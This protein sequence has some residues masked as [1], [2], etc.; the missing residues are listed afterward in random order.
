M[1]I[2][3]RICV[4][5]VNNNI[6]NP[7]SACIT[8]FFYTIFSG[9]TCTNIAGAFR[10]TLANLQQLNPSLNCAA[11]TPGQRICVPRIIKK[12]SA[13]DIAVPAVFIPSPNGGCS[14]FFGITSGDTCDTIANILK[15]SVT[16]LLT[17]NP[18]LNCDKLVM[19]SAIC[20]PSLSQNNNNNNNIQPCLN[21]YQI[22]YGDI[23]FD[24]AIRA[25]ISLGDFLKLNPTVNCD[26]LR[27]GEQVC[28]AASTNVGRKQ[29]GFVTNY[30]VQRGD[31]CFALALR[32]RLD[33]RLFT[34]A[35][36]CNHLQIGQQ[37]CI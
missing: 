33:L 27:V 31:T 16:S 34:Q 22:Q 19:G 17:A 12:R 3:A 11:L 26:L 6:I 20:V 18:T 5:S 13:K 24:I 30:V 37:I 25:Q 2:G 29:C 15:T 8:G 36:D 1:P 10:S 14:N 28:V 32:Y 21:S 35:L 23:C 7:Q 9:D 4:P